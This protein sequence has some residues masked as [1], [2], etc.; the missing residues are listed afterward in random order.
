M[1]VVL[2]SKKD[3]YYMPEKI[4]VH[5]PVVTAKSTSLVTLSGEEI[6]CDVLLLCSGKSLNILNA[7]L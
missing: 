3:S 1:Q 5:T 7:I 4:V 6:Q 2:S